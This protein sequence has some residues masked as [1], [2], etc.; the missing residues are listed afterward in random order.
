[1]PA[2]LD[3]LSFEIVG[4]VNLNMALHKDL[5]GT[6]EMIYATEDGTP[7]NLTGSQGTLTLTSS[8]CKGVPATNF[9]L[10]STEIGNLTLGAD[11]VITFIVDDDTVDLAVNGVYDY[12]FLLT[13]GDVVQQLFSGLFEINQE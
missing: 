6:L 9:I 12:N 13:S 2:Y 1:M 8:S 3:P 7:V 11:G 10:F 5:R 4:D